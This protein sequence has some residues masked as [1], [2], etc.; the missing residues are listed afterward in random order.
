[1]GLAAAIAVLAPRASADEAGFG[2]VPGG[3]AVRMLDAEGNPEHRA[4]AHPDRVQI[5]FAF[6]GEESPAEIDFE[7]PPGFSGNLGAVPAC[8]RQAHEEGEEC[9]PQTQVGTFKLGPAGGSGTV[10]PVYNL[11]PGTGEAAAFASRT[12]VELHSSLELRPGD[13]GITMT[14]SDLPEFD[15]GEAHFELWGVPADHQEGT[16][17]ERRPFLAAPSTCGPLAFTLRARSRE[18]GA[19]WLSDTTQTSPAQSG[20]ESLSFG[21][22]LGLALTDPVADSPTGVRM[23]IVG[24]G[25]EDADGLA[26]AQIR[27]VAVELPPGLTIAPAGATRLV[28]CSDAQ[29]DLGGSGEPACPAG[30]RVGSVEVE[31]PSFGE[32]LSGSVYLGQERPGER[33]RLFVAVPGPGFVLK[34]AGSLHADPVTGRLAATLLDLPQATIG[35]LEMRLGG[36]P[37]SLIASPL[38]CGTAAATASFVPYG[39]GAPMASSASVFVGA[40]LPGLLCPGP[41]PFTPE[42]LLERSSRRAAQVTSLTTTLKRRDGELLPRR[43][44]IGLPPG[45]SAVLGSVRACAP[46]DLNATCPEESRIGGVVIQAGPGQAQ[47]TLRGDVY[48]T[49]PYRRAPFGLLVRVPAELGPFDLGTI[50]FR[51]ALELND[52]SGRVTIISD[53]LPE[54]IEGVQVRLRAIELSLDRPGFLRNPTGCRPAHVSGAVEAT[55]GVSAPVSTVLKTFGCGKLHFEPRFHVTLESD[56]IKPGVGLRM[57]AHLRRGEAA[58]RAM[59]V[60]L[61]RAIELSPTGVEA[62]CSR[63]DA[64]HQEC[65]GGARIGT[66]RARTPLFDEPLSGAV[67]LVRPEGDGQPDMWLTLSRGDLRFGLSGR[68]EVDDGHFVAKLAGFPDMPLSSLTMRLGEAGGGALTLSGDPCARSQWDGLVFG[69]SLRGQNGARRR[70]RV[71]VATRARC[72]AHRRGR[73]ASDAGRSHPERG[74]R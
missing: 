36:G 54:A 63:P 9:S 46:A 70:L 26:D 41:L 65:P 30:S 28:A 47:A 29:L 7:M 24:P 35:R 1:L 11:E 21:P 14:I 15:A 33:F 25:E 74:R 50:A 22:H 10:L 57:V 68:T 4:G 13:F 53:P 2:L 8:P 39:G 64:L 16:P 12:D 20:C 69:L 56:G 51:A 32:P 42:I 6:E 31:S 66:A 71:P 49:G 72:R 48:L 67:Y 73:G 17:G 43:F 18:E 38:A 5:D 52:R 62:I 55:S 60:S 23:E 37:G 45:L 3:F 40:R 34:F 19:A 58:V 27:D 61:P 59:R 44:A